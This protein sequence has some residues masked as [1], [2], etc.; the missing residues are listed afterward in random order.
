MEMDFISELHWR[1]KVGDPTVLGWLT[2]AVYAATV[3]L[4]LVTARSL[5]GESDR[6]KLWTA[7]A[8]V[9]AFLG[10]NKQLYFQ[11]LVT[12]LGRVIALHAGSY[13][14]RRSFQGWAV[15]GVLVTAAIFA[16]WLF[17][18]FRRVWLRQRMLIA[19]LTLL[20]TLMIV[21][22]ISFHPVDVLL[23]T[24]AYGLRLSVVLELVGVLLIGGAAVKERRACRR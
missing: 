12:D 5:D 11:S 18:R 6:R 13:A 10:L 23:H 1:P 8:A 3:V 15:L 17:C 7:V 14:Q 9:M 22:A 4:S 20:L 19:G 24:S 16:G 21:R 2:V